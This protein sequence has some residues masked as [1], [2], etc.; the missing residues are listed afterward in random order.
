MREHLR[1]KFFYNNIKLIIFIT[2][3]IIYIKYKTV[4]FNVFILD[5]NS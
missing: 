5:K 1:K 2:I 3:F 4:N